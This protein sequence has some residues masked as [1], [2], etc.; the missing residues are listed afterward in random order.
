MSLARDP[1]RAGVS[2]SAICTFDWSLE[3]DLAFYAEHGITNVGISLVKLERHGWA[4]GAARVRDA[5]LR[6]TNLIGLGPFHLAHP[7]AVGAATRAA[8]ARARRGRDRRRRVP[9][10]HDRSGRA[11]DLGGRRR[12]ARGGDRPGARR[13]RAERRSRSRSSTRTRCGS[14]SASCTRCATSSTSPGV[15]T[16]ACAWRSTRAGPSAASA[17]TIAGAA[18]TGIRLVQV[19]DFAVGTLS[20]PNRLVPGDGDIPLDRILGQVLDAGYAGC[21]DLELIGPAIEAEGYAVR[22]SPARSSD[23]GAT[24]LRDSRPRS[25]R[26][27]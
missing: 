1:G 10:R 20:T 15:S 9:G 8:D 22:R 6:V 21:F 25:R 14:T 27:R 12:R 16:S 23:L 7:G 18:S 24:L 17:A 26:A 13:R 2:V 5:G 4:D 11:A 19:S 3:E